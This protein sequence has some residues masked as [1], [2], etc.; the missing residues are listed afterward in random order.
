MWAFP[1]E[2]LRATIGIVVFFQYLFAPTLREEMVNK[3]WLVSKLWL[4]GDIQGDGKILHV[5]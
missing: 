2:S 1:A 3:L 5:F 4:E